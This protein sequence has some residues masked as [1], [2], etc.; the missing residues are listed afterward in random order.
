MNKIGEGLYA[1]VFM[2][3]DGTVVKRLKCCDYG[4][5]V[6]PEIRT[7]EK[8]KKEMTDDEEKRCFPVLYSY[9][10]L[11]STVERKFVVSGSDFS[12]EQS[13]HFA[14]LNESRW[15]CEM[16]MDYKGAPFS[17]EQFFDLPREKKLDFVMQAVRIL[18]ILY[19][20]GIVHRD[21]RFSNFTYAANNGRYS[22]VDFGAAVTKD[23]PPWADMFYKKNDLHQLVSILSNVTG[24]HEHLLEM[25]NDAPFSRPVIHALCKAFPTDDMRKDVLELVKKITGSS[26]SRALH[27]TGTRKEILDQNIAIIEVYT[28][29]KYEQHYKTFF[30]T[31]GLPM[32]L[33]RRDLLFLIYDN[34]N[35]SYDQLLSAIQEKAI[36]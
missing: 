7:L 15:M 22:L 33:V 30:A 2:D 5:D 36:I 3:E 11:P 10:V 34:W 18:A 4:E 21:I 31:D 14:M 23:M 25:G 16:R 28:R 13:R 35:G 19:K 6:M 12:V 17:Q 29:L 27:V 9:E 26:S 24:V 20:H 1:E 32:P 8:I